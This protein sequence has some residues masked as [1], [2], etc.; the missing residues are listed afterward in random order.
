MPRKLLRL[1]A[2]CLFFMM[3][4]AGAAAEAPRISL[5]HTRWLPSDG[6]PSYVTSLAQ[7]ADGWLWVASS[8]GLYRFDGVR[9]EAFPGAG[10]EQLLYTDISS[11]RALGDDVWV[12]YRYGGATLV[13]QGRIVKHY[14]AH[15]DAL[16]GTTWDFARDAKGQ[17]W[18]ATARGLYALKDDT[19]RPVPVD[20]GSQLA[21]IQ[22]LVDQRGG[23]W[24]R[25]PDSIY[26][27]ASGA[28][29]FR[30]VADKLGWGG[31]LLQ[32]DGS[33][34]AND[35][36]VG[37]VR[38]LQPPRGGA[39]PKDWRPSPGPTG[40]M[41]VDHAG[42]LWNLRPD[43]VEM[44]NP[45]AASQRLSFQ[46]GL[47]GETG[48]AILVDREGNIWV[49]TNGGLDR[50]RENKLAAYPAMPSQGQA[51]PLAVG[52]NGE[53]WSDKQV[54]DSPDA[55]PVIYD[56]TA[57]T[58]TNFTVADF[59]DAQGRYWTHSFD[60]LSRIERT[61]Q[62]FTRTV[63]APPA[64]L[65]KG[66]AIPGPGLGADADGG[67]W[68]I[69]RANLYRYKDGEWSRDGGRKDLPKTGYTSI[70]SA[71]NG[72]LWFG[73][74]KNLI[75]S[76]RGDQLL[77]YDE[78]D[79]VQLGAISQFYADG[80]TLWVGG[81]NGVMFG[82]GRRFYKVQGIGGQQFL[83][84]TGIAR[85]ADGDLWLNSGAG[86][87]RISSQQ[88]KEL[89]KN[90]AYKVSFEVLNHQDGLRGV[91]AQS[92]GPSSMVFARGRIWLSTT[93]GVFWIDPARTVLNKA[94]PTVVINGLTAND[95]TY[96][97]EPGITLPAG[98]TRV[99]LDYTAL[100]LTMPERMRFRY[101][102]HGVDEYAQEAVNQRSA[103]YTELGAGTYRF[104]VQASNND[105][106][107][108]DTA[109][110][111]T[112]SIKPT[113]VQTW[114]FKGA[115]LL[116]VLLFIW[117]V[118]RLRLYHVAKQVRMKFEERLDERERI[119]RELHDSLLQSVQAMMLIIGNAARRLT[120]PQEK[121]DIESALERAELA[122]QEGRD[123][124]QGLRQADS[125]GE[126]FDRLSAFGAQLAQHGPCG[127]TPVLHGERRRLHP[128]VGEEIR[129]IGK[130]AL[131]NAFQHAQATHIQVEVRYGAREF[132]LTVSDNGHGIPAAVLAEGGREGHWGLT[133]MR[134]RARKIDATLECQSA[135]GNGTRWQLTLPAR[136]A[137][138]NASAHAQ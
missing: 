125:A 123:H 27:S 65:P 85:S 36:G 66:G 108:N 30:L 105:G 96:A 92:G 10:G 22:M 33:V 41:A 134:E 18:A 129:A 86:V 81:N 124:V 136:L 84:T 48:T 40:Q 87:F 74:R 68:A 127:F 49:G 51:L 16:N 26:H 31:L 128:V 55:P 37:G 70:C 32:P 76:L 42:R 90:P 21:V 138:P 131:A 23:F 25:S 67:I 132:Q 98:T 100:S 73:T 62:G 61:A 12:G 79:G 71:P 6:A 121:A 77:T 126:L 46:Q 38:L 78:K 58:P 64:D 24:L 75:F 83:G 43:G 11:V 101:R 60:A 4:C 109:A 39:A 137:Y 118:H 102:L 107:W 44:L 53:V 59:V 3:T 8:I 82:D 35:H 115:L 7:S 34:A 97:A 15:K 56:K 1:F 110:V 104:E 52:K 119:A 130:E 45:A 47:S 91:A 69:F 112:F 135:A 94:K 2:H 17:L 13:R 116:I 93:S 111:L 103:F 113:I 133:G 95:V 5:H 88:Q 9:F 114:W 57:P 99:R 29:P 19:F 106:V 20:L 122:I 14:P 120:S 117:G 50:F 54:F 72:V 80:P 63:I 28:A 89:L